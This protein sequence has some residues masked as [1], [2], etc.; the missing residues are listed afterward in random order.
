MGGG[1]RR[2]RLVSGRMVVSCRYPYQR[3]HMLRPCEIN[4]NVDFV[5]LPGSPFITQP[6][7]FLFI[8]IPRVTKAPKESTVQNALIKT[9]PSS[10]PTHLLS[11]QLSLSR[12]SPQNPPPPSP[13]IPTTSRPPR[14]TRPRKRILGK[15][16]RKRLLTTNLLTAHKTL[17]S[18][19]NG[20]VN[21]LR[22]AVLGETHAT[23]GFADADYGF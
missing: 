4:A 1:G 2:C 20:A 8:I 10:P 22:G 13:R 7:V 15:R 16:P 18:N 9:I 17:N 6:T 23:E 19:S 12:N 14:L 3:S 21:V 5:L 11:Y